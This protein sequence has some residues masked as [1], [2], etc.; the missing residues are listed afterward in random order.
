MS[1]SRIAS[2]YAK[3]LFDL[4]KSE[5]KLAE[6]F[7]DIQY[8][9]QVN[10][11]PD[12]ASTMKNPLIKE[13]V[14]EGIFDKI[15]KGKVQKITLNTLMVMVEHNREAFLNDICRIFIVLY[16]EENNIST[17]TLTSAFVLKKEQKDAILQAFQ[18]KGLI[19]KDIELKEQINPELLGGFILQYK[20]MVYNASVKS[21][22]D[23][24]RNKFSENLY[25]K[26]F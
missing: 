22:L 6:V 23:R 19:S 21:K 17:L 8:V 10:E 1:V 11:L 12:F 24:L 14:K 18:E 4:A 26:K 3:S 16:Q 20:D 2:R 5:G 9:K 7:Q 25:N 15:F 13:D